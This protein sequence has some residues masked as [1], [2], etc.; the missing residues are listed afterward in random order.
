M[1]SY[2]VRRP[3]YLPYGPGPRVPRVAR[4][5]SRLGFEV[6][7][8]NAV[9]GSLPLQV[10]LT[11]YRGDDF[12]LDVE[13]T[14]SGGAPFDLTGYTA[15]A[16]IRATADAADPPAASFDPVIAGSTIHLH[17]PHGEA[18]GLP[19]PNGA[20]DVQITDATGIVTTLAF[21]AVTTTPD[22]TRP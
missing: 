7:P 9:A 16:Q 20:W 3:R 2:T 1:S 14:D 8:L 13:V 5:T 18:T 15:A 4:P 17:L 19:T 10:D 21:G 12:F 11:L 6:A 22:V